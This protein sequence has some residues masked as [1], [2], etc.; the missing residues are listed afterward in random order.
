MAAP[1]GT[2]WGSVVSGSANPTGRQ[3]RLGIYTSVSST[4]TQTTVSVQVWFWTIYSCSDGYDDTLYYNVGTNI[5]SATTQVASN[6]DIEHTVV[7]GDGW[8]ISNQTR[9]YTTTHTYNRGTSDT[10]YKIYAKFSGIDMLDGAVNANTSFTVPKLASYT[11]SYNNNGG[12]GS[13]YSQTKYYG[14]T[15]TLS[16]T[17]PTRSG[18]TFIGWG[19]SSTDTTSDYSAGGSYTANSG[20]TLYAIWSK[21]ITLT[22]NNNGGS[23]SPSAQS[24]T[25]YNATTSYT[26]TLSSTKPTRTGYTFLGWSTSSG[27]TSASYSSGGTITLSNSSTLYA[28]WQINTWT[29]S[30]NANGGSGAPSNQTKTYGQTLTLSSTKPTRSGYTFV[31]WGTSASDT[32]VDYNAGGSYTANAAITLY[33]IW[34]KTIILSYNA[35]NGSGAPS[36]QS[37]TI[38]NATTSYSFTVSSTKPTRAGYKFLG[39]S[40]SSTATSATYSSGS[41]ITLSDSVTLYA[42]WEVYGLLRIGDK[43]YIPYAYYN[44]SWIQVIPQAYYNGEWKIGG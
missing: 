3:G 29:V 11:V 1:S 9:L 34:S 5:S 37:A 28:V 13:P 41:T 36:S 25:V 19:T 18:Y 16:S 4:N 23:G 2:V 17:K 40:T 8:S 21:T 10:T 26:F 24:A 12:S 15:L 39:W 20:A 30:Y 43:S 38:Y 35:N 42:V 32:T 7:S 14:Q 22:Y 44:S 31:G 27:A 33:A 6:I